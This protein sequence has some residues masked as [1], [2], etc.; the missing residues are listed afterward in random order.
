MKGEGNSYKVQPFLIHPSGS[1]LS[2]SPVGFKK[3]VAFNIVQ[4]IIS[5]N[6]ERENTVAYRTLLGGNLTALPIK[7]Q[8]VEKILHRV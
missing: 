3:T 5:A 6:R 8:S 2:T 1:D 7:A 4:C